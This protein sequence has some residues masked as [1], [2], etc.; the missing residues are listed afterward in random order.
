MVEVGIIMGSTSDMP[1]MQ[2]AMDV[3]KELGIEFEVNIVS[4]HRTPELMFDYAKSAHT[5]GLKVIIAGAGGAAHLPG[6][7]A[8]LT[9]LPVIGV[10]VK[11]RN[12]IDGWDSILSILQMPGGIPVATVALNGAKNAGILA[13]KI[14]ASANPEVLKTLLSYMDGMKEKVLNNAAEI[15]T[16]K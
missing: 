12:S 4:A 8:S 13:A 5:R 10:P 11:S 6:M 1:V 14:I 16:F 3:L 15:N 9:P 2:E 7:T